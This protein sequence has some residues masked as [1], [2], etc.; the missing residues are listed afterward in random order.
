MT[1]IITAPIVI[2]QKRPARKPDLAKMYGRPRI[3]APMIVP[4]N[5][6]VVAQNCFR[7][8]LED[9]F[10]VSPV[11]LRLNSFLIVLGWG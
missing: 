3:P 6:N 1:N 9:F 7:G 8:F 2:S 5:V 4:L 10:I 11:V